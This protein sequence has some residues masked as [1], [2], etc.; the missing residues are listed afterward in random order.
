MRSIYLQATRAAV[1]GLVVN[2]ALGVIKLIAGLAIA[3]SGLAIQV[4]G[5]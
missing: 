2:A 1:L 4:L 3:A 5:I